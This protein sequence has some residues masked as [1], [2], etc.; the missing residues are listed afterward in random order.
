MPTITGTVVDVTGRK[1][2]RAWR[3]WSPVYRE[4]ESGHV[5]TM[6]EQPVRV[7]AGVLTVELEPGVAVIENPDGTQW[8]VTVPDTDTTLWPLIQAA[9]MLP[10]E[11]PEDQLAAAIEA[12]F[13]TH[14]VG[15]GI[16]DMQASVYDPTT[17]QAD[18]FSQDNMA[19]GT[20]NKN[21]TAA[22][23][24][25]LAGVAAGATA[26]STDAQ[27]RDRG[28]HT[29]TQSADTITDGTTNRAYTATEKTKLA[30]IATGATAN[31]T[32]ANLKNRANHTG[33]Q[34]A[35]TI[36]DFNTAA[37]ARITAAGLQATS[38]KN[39]PNGYAGLD[40]S[41]LI[42][43][44]L[45]PSYVDDVLEYANTG[46]FPGT[47]TTGKIFVAVDTGK[48]YRWSGSV[49]VEISPSPG[50]TDAVP[51]GA[52]NQYYTAT[53][54]DA[55]I[56]AAIG[57]T[58]QGYNSNTT[59]LGNSTTGTG[60]IV[61]DTSPT[62][63]TPA[64]GTPASGDLTNCTFPTLNQNTTGNAATATA[65]AAYRNFQTNLASTSSVAFNG[66]SNATPGVTGILPVTNGGTGANTLT[67][68]AKGNGTSA[69]TAATAGTDYVAPGGALGTPSS[70]NLANCTFPT[71]NQ[72]TTGNA[73]TATKL[74]TA[75][76]IN[77]VPFDGTGNI[78]TPLSVAVPVWI[79]VH[80]TYGARAVGYGDNTMGFLS[81][82]S[83]T[84][85][86]IV[87]RGATADASGSSTVEVRQNGTQITG[88]SKTITAA[89]QWGYGANVT[90]TGLSIAVAAGD[91]LRPYISAV[92]TTPGFG[93]SAV[94][95][96]TKTVTA[97]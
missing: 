63:T 81:P 79:E 67:G 62:L 97:S 8:R 33:T 24:T 64:L 4:G 61:R 69:M 66:T 13:D 39:Q 90:V 42:P 43:A 94:I 40:S 80:A 7:S 87:F 17:R 95:I 55:R 11:T 23:K 51:E 3:A 28:T 35:S 46:A 14:P 38:E 45:L 77:G 96:G 50:S 58:V 2:S 88:S 86:G 19:D 68:L 83:F 59:Q 76:N 31:D 26:N 12:Y 56:S 30:G 92:G 84:L 18:A 48:I 29:G 60:S 54:A 5:V 52:T 57:V 53:R 47:G 10:P 93:F 85:T 71:L 49:Y 89:N 34:T 65:L 37:D 25:K 16:G 72:S 74:A 22:E 75:R 20:A 44:V 6:E 36:S 82:D 1:D 70:G 32:D 9:V 27:L 15:P 78:V 21:Y 73:A 41:A 91:V